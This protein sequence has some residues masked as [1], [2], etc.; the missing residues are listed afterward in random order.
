MLISD[1]H[2][3][4]FVH[5]YKAAGSS[6][7][8]ALR[9]YAASSIDRASFG[10]RM[11]HRLRLASIKPYPHHLK[12]SEIRERFPK[13]WDGYFTFAFVRNPWDWQ[14]SLYSYMQ[15]R[16]QHWQHDLAKSFSNF[17]EYLDW[18][19]NEDKHLQQEFLCDCNGQI[20]VDFVGRVE[21]IEKD[22]EYICG[23]IGIVES[24]PHKNKSKHRDYKSYYDDYTRSLVDEHFA[25]DIER[26]GYSFDGVKEE[27]AT[28][29]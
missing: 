13:E 24:L 6:V 12:A 19:V 29:V 9:P 1:D 2:Q 28:I 8:E 16:E 22:F 14:V 17:R 18:R 10:E 7:K 3:F 5:L 4:I 21:T 15:Q 20:I 25:L 11:L 26:F 23:E 27:N